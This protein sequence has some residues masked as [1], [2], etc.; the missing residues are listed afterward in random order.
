MSRNEFVKFNNDTFL[1]DEHYTLS[2]VDKLFSTVLYT[3]TIGI[4]YLQFEIGLMLIAG[5]KGISDKDLE[6]III[7]NICRENFK[8]SNQQNKNTICKTSSILTL[9]IK[10]KEMG[11]ACVM[12]IEADSTITD[13]KYKVNKKWNVNINK[14]KLY[15]KEFEK[16]LEDSKTLKYYSIQNNCQLYLFE[17]HSTITP[18]IGSLDEEKNIE[19]EIVQVNQL[20]ILNQNLNLIIIHM[21]K[22]IIVLKI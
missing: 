21:K 19:F 5:K 15:Y 11:L 22:L 12:D 13:L 14:H 17:E 1:I 4:N 9:N 3:N 8:S 18:T 16:S 7:N 20:I 10:N 2:D 6:K